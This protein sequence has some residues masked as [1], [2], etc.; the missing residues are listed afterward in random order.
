MI[1]EGGK[2]GQ[3]RSCSGRA[4]PLQPALVCPRGGWER[5][6]REGPGRRVPAECPLRAGGGKIGVLL[7][8]RARKMTLCLLVFS[9][10]VCY[11]LFGHSWP[12]IHCSH[13]YREGLLAVVLASLANVVDQEASL[14][15]FY[16]I[17][18]PSP[19]GKGLNLT[20]T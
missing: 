3:L 7:L 17:H 20:E 19:I 2:N 15:I 18:C 4:E 11:R 14:L 8:I 12:V 5:R 1:K 13:G 6:P 9:L 16:F 10:W